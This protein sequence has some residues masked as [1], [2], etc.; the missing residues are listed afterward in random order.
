M[1]KEVLNK[2]AKCKNSTDFGNNFKSVKPASDSKPLEHCSEPNDKNQFDFGGPILYEEKNTYICMYFSF[3]HLEQSS[4]CPFVSCR[5]FE[6]LF[7]QICRSCRWLTG[8]ELWLTNDRDELLIEETITWAQINA[9]RW[10][11]GQKTSSLLVSSFKPV[12]INLF[13]I[14]NALWN[15]IWPKKSWRG[16]NMTFMEFTRP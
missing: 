5:Y 8:W 2:A 1:S 3:I 12:W 9:S 13:Y 10:Y 15:S 4:P 14:L 6:L 7:R 11:K 16:R